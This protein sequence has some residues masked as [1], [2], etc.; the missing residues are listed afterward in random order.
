MKKLMMIVLVIA[1][2]AGLV[3]MAGCGQKTETTEETPAG[4]AATDTQVAT[5]DCDGDCGM[6]DVPME[7]LKEV[8]GK[9]YCAGCVAHMETGEESETAHD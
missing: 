2:S 1:M 6:K 9:Y 5:H 8:D 3:L 7:H 4:E